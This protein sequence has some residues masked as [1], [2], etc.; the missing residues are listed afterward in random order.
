M[1]HNHIYGYFRNIEDFVQNVCITL[2]GKRGLHIS[3]Q[4]MSYDLIDQ[5]LDFN[6]AYYKDMRR[7]IANVLINECQKLTDHFE[8]IDIFH[9][10]VLMSN[11]SK[12][13]QHVII[14]NETT[15]ITK[16][17]GVSG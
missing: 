1:A 17:K 3:F 11:M 5:E 15:T 14:T 13:E 12:M 7:N 10:I 16:F 4:F 9:A 8:R 6:E 2:V